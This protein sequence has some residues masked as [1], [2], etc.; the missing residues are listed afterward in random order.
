MIHVSEYEYTEIDLAIVLQHY[1]NL[2]L[3]LGWQAV[4]VDSGT[5][6]VIYRR[7]RPTPED[8]TYTITTSGDTR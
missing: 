5:N 2:A 1:S 7:V 8:A 3:G 4:A 6:R